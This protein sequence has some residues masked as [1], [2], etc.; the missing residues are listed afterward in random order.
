MASRCILPFW[1]FFLFLPENVQMCVWNNYAEIF[2]LRKN[3]CL[4]AKNVKGG[5]SVRM[6]FIALICLVVFAAV[7]SSSVIVLSSTQMAEKNVDFTNSYSI[8]QMGDGVDVGP[9][10]I[11]IDTPGGPG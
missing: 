1:Q 4:F 8:A 3:R 11:A 5:G 2:L 7:A 6:K 10:G 9:D